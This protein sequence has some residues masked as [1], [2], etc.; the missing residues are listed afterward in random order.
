MDA[1]LTQMVRETM[2]GINAKLDEIKRIQLY[3]NAVYR[4]ASSQMLD[5]NEVKSILAIS[6]STFRKRLKSPVNPLQMSL[7]NGRYIITRESLLEWLEAE[8]IDPKKLN[9]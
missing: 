9:V 1:E 8:N 7:I 3:K 6:D 2:N 4:S 5:S